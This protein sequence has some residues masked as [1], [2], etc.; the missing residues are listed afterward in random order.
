M[1]KV[2][3]RKQKDEENPDEYLTRL[4]ELFNTYSGLQLLDKSSNTPDVL[5]IHLC[6]CFLNGLKPDIASAVKISCIGWNDARMSEL[7]RHDQDRN[8]E[9]KIPSDVC[10]LCGQRGH[11]RRDCPRNTSS[12]PADKSD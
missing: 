1:G 7:R 8:W 3:T 2:N 10:F 5:E 6:N 4:T 12:T 11:W 9:R